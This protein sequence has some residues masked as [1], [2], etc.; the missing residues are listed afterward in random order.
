MRKKCGVIALLLMSVFFADAQQTQVYLD[1][2]QG[3]S[4][5]LELFDEHNYLAAR[6][7]FEEIYKQQHNSTWHGNTVLIQNL[8]YYI[9]VCAAE[10]NDKDAESLLLGYFKNYHET[11][12]RRLIYL[13]LG[14]YYYRNKKYQETIDYLAKVKTEDLNNQQLYDYRF[15][16]AYAYFT[17]KKFA[18]AKPL[19][20]SIKD[21]KDKYYYPAT[22]Y[23]AFISFFN[24]DYNDALKS[25]KDIEDSKMY[26]SVIPY[27]ISQIYFYKKEYDTLTPY[28]KKNLDKP[29]V[30]YKDE[31]KFLLGKVYFQKNEYAKA[32]PLL[33]EYINKAPKATKEDIYQ[34]AYCQYKTGNY[35]KA[36]DNF[37]QLNILEE[38]LGQTATYALADCYL[39]TNQKD[40]AR[41]AFQS[42][43]SMNYDETIKQNALFNY[44]KLSFEAGQTSEAIQSFEDYLDKYSNGTY[45]DEVNEL[46]AAALVQTKNYDKA[47]RIMEHMKMTSPMIKEAYQRVTYFRAVELYN[48]TKADEA[49]QLCDKSLS[50]GTDLVITALATYLKAEIQYGKADY[51][52]ARLNYMKFSQMAT[53]DVE[54]KGEASKFRAQYNT[55]YCY[56][57]KKSYS[58]AAVYFDAAT[59]EAPNS[60]DQKGVKA[61]QADLYLRLADCNFV[62]K[63]YNK[64]IDAYSVI[65]DN[66][67]NAAEYAQYQ[68]GIILGLQNRNAEKITAMNSLLSK[69]P[70][71]NYADRAM[72]EIAETYLD[73]ENYSAART[74]YQ[75]L[76]SKYPGSQL[77][78]S[79]YM[80]TAI[81]DYSLGKKELAIEDY[82]SV[83]KKYPGSKEEKEA[84][85]A[86]KDI[87]V[88]VGKANEYFDFV[89]NNTNIQVSTYEQDSLTYQSAENVYNSGNCERAIEL[90]GGYISQFPGTYKT[91]EAHWKK[92]Q[93][94]L[95][96]KD[97]A[98]AFPDLEAVIEAKY[99][100]YY[101]SA[102]IKAT[103]IAYFELKNYD[104]ALTYYKQLYVASSKQENTYNAMIG[105]LASAVKL[106]KNEEVIELADQ[107]IN[108]GIA[109]ETDI[110]DAYY[111]KGKAYYALDN[112]EFA[113]SAFKRVVEYPVSEKCVE[114]KYMLAKILFEQGNYKQSLDTCF[115]LKNKYASYEYWVVKTFILMADNYYAQNNSFQAKSTLESIVANYEGDKALLSEAKEK[116]EKI[117]A[118]EL[119]KSKLMLIA[120]SDTLI[121]ESDS[122]IINK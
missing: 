114:S 74:S 2:E 7:K 86:L 22:Y 105:M 111:R 70:T 71:S 42:A 38:P 116:L 48:D 25:F 121:M 64:A 29:E 15:M 66:N 43:A 92:A 13:Y 97:Y 119:N 104:K 34:L 52:N 90:Y 30:L 78:P 33:E 12:K 115:K 20:A 3:F 28:I 72:Y 1:P 61:L 84:V 23:Y 14:K 16:L 46:L 18:E 102:L 65:V 75:S 120:P 108:S 58:D 44:G 89:K 10:T 85:D 117:R 53:A 79:A 21:V 62:T 96:V 47:Y 99:A 112:K 94:H 87:Y 91:S 49:L 11:D 27:Y 36:I 88:E 57:K 4:K 69:F 9:A 81:V 24:K 19:F 107:L 106:N 31:M 8:E 98:A 5:G 95:K 45:V 68:K 59:N 17:K 51:D 41:S 103:G 63:N 110:Q 67:W 122:I 26:S 118:E 39:Q 83:V 55:A 32:L 100:K 80:K 93:C 6:E 101:E 113:Q 73:D 77:V 37:K 82:K 76:I 109:K 40:K 50:G 56:F 35:N 54:K 60:I